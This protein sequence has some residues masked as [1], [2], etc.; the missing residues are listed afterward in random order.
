MKKFL[1]LMLAALMM[2]ALV[3]CG[4]NNATNGNA[5]ETTTAAG[6]TDYSSIKMGLICL[7]DENSTYDANFIQAAEAA[8]KELGFELVKK[9]NIPEDDSCAQAAEELAEDG[10]DIIFAD[11]FGHET[12]MMTVAEE[13]PEVQF[14]HATGT[15]AKT[16]DMANYHN[17]FASIYEG[18]YLAGI[19]AGMKINEMIKE[20]KFTA[21]EAKMGYV[22]AYPYAEVISGY[23]SFY[24]GA[25]SVCPS[26]T[27]TVKYTNSWFDIALEK[28]AADAL[29]GE[30]CILIS[31]HADSEGAPK[32]CEEKGVPN[33]AYNVN[34]INLGPTTAIISSKIDWTPYFKLIVEAV[35]KGEAIPDDWCGSIA[36]GSVVLT[37]LN[38]DVAAE[39]T[40]DAIDAAIKEFK[41]GTLKVFNTANFTVDGETLESYKADVVPDANFEKDTEVVSDG[42]F[43]ESEMRSAPY[44][45]II[46]DGIT[47]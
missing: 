43:H 23:T 22:G 19:A 35:A 45:D 7:H 37:E 2:F 32:A 17:A 10:C 12:Y 33:V 16:S 26:V 13:Y 5:D 44:F 34:T 27:M 1:A 25:K 28:E 39:G 18:R 29:I 8:S 42:Y 21:E 11:S 38:E 14:C 20:G 30:G 4:G 46:I 31:Q 40:Q 3:A 15:N 41:E 36:T 24:L 9:V 6:T 47:A